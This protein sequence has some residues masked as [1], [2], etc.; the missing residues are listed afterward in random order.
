MEYEEYLRDKSVIIVMPSKAT[1]GKVAG[2]FIDSFDLVVRVGHSYKIK[3]REDWLGSKAEIIY[4][5]L[6]DDTDK[7]IRQLNVNYICTLNTKF[8]CTPNTRKRRDA[9][10]PVKKKLLK[11]KSRIQQR[12]I[13][14]KRQVTKIIGSKPLMGLWAVAD[15]LNF[16]L[17]SLY[18]YGMDFYTTGYISKYD[19]RKNWPKQIRRGVSRDNHNL[20]QSKNYIKKLIENDD[21]VQCDEITWSALQ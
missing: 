7:G 4:H 13:S 9:L 15:L 3:G 1:E 14:D 20:K 18:I 17:K 2:D 11:N 5:S 21:R 16:D 19:C 10:K 6:R 12:F 8:L